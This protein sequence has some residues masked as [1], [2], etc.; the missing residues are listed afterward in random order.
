MPLFGDDFTGMSLISSINLFNWIMPVK[1]AKN[2]T[3]IPSVSVTQD[4]S[5]SIRNSVKTSSYVNSIVDI[6]SKTSFSAEEFDEIKKDKNGRPF[7]VEELA[8]QVEIMGVSTIEK[9]SFEA[10]SRLDQQVVDELKKVPIN[11]SLSSTQK[12]LIS[13]YRYHSDFAKK[14]AD[15]ELKKE[16]IKRLNEDYLK[17]T[18]YYLPTLQKKITKAFNGEADQ[19]VL[20]DGLIKTAKALG[21]FPAFGGLITSYG[22]IC[23]T[24]F[25]FTV[26][27]VQGGWMW[28]YY[29][30]MAIITPASGSRA[31]YVIYPSVY[32]KGK[33][34]PGPGICT[35][36]LVDAHPSG[37][38]TVILYGSSL[39]Y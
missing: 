33:S 14:M 1:K 38:A 32:I 22:E 28:I 13:W 37:I 29:A 36:V 19:F 21:G 7:S 12:D 20:F 26:S 2:S 8:K 39:V 30:T 6:W 34:I 18:S 24:G 35:R 15:K 25:S 10:W 27:G 9:K 23:L 3:G 4:S 11:S 16:E 5:L 31:N 17:N